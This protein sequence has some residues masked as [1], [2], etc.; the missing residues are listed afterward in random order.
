MSVK[1]IQIVA[2]VF[3]DLQNTRQKLL[4]MGSKKGAIDKQDI[5]LA[6][7]IEDMKEATARKFIK[8]TIGK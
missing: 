4:A 7:L 6:Q 8:I 1:G 3:L 2:E 5:Q